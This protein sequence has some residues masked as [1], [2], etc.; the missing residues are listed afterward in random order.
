MRSRPLLFV[1]PLLA[2]VALCAQSRI[3]VVL[4][5]DIGSDIDDALTLAFLLRSPE[6]DVRAVVTS[7]FAADVRARLALKLL[8][9]YGR[10]ELPL[11]SGADD[12]LM[13]KQTRRENPQLSV[14]SEAETLPPGAAYGGVRLMIDTILRSPDKV[15]V[16]AVGPLSNV[17][18]A[19]RTDPRIRDHIA[20]IAVMGGATEMLYA[21]TNIVNDIAAAAIVF[22]SGLP[23]L[24]GPYDVTKDLEWPAGDVAQLFAARTPGARLL[25]QLTGLWRA[26]R[27][28]NPILHDVLPLIGLLRPEWCQIVNGRIEVEVSSP[29]TRGMTKFTPAD[30][31]PKGV[32]GNVRLIR[33]VDR[34]RLFELFTQRVTSE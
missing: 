3:P 11:A 22:D 32:D 21:E 1:A 14:V 6:F 12:G 34:A 9:L 33:K 20:Q 18:L 27:Q 29:I 4:D 23:V 26:G 13:N 31:L 5:T 17:A 15:T 8:R 7:R 19:L 16:V 28:R 30:R 25:T 10:G 2:A 24:L